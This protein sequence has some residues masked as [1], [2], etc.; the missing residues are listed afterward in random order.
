MKR[1]F[2]ALTVFLA[3]FLARCFTATDAPAATRC[4]D[5]RQ[6]SAPDHSR[7]VIDLDGPPTYNIPAPAETLVLTVSLQKTIL[8]WQAREIPVD[9]RVIRKMR[10]GQLHAAGGWIERGKKLIRNQHF[11]FGEAIQQC[12]FAS[13]GVANYRHG[14]DARA[15]PLCAVA[16]AV[17]LHFFKLAF[18]V[19]D[20]GADGAFVNFKLRFA[21]TAQTNTAS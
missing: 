8:P 6:W 16:C 19:C 13:I 17:R 10:I 1:G 5:I 7:V 3:I 21:W 20:A 15:L 2:L 18:D 9:A 4:L 12:G 14:W 11:R